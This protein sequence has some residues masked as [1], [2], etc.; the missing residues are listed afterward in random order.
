[1]TG[2]GSNI[3]NEKGDQMNRFKCTECGGGIQDQAITMR[4]N[5]RNIHITI[6][7]IP[8]KVC[9]KCKNQLVSGY[10]AK[11]VDLLVNRISNDLER[12]IKS[13]ALPTHRTHS[14][15]LAI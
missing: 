15:S 6:K 2:N 5:L 13:L 10:T 3:K 14:I 1:M 8:A 12:F 11:D 4:Y 7:N 9:V